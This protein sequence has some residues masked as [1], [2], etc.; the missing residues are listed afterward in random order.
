[1]LSQIGRSRAIPRPFACSGTPAADQWMRDV[2]REMNLSETAFLVPE[3][4]GF[5]PALVHAGGG[6]GPL[7]SRHR[8]QRA[9]PLGRCT[10]GGRGPGAV[11]HTQ[12]PVAGGPARR[13]DRTG[14]SRDARVQR[15]PR[16]PECSRPWAAAASVVARNGS[17][18]CWS[19]TRKKAVRGLTPDFSALRGLEMRG[20]IVTARAFHGGLRFRFP[21]LR[22]RPWAWM[23]TR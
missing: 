20:V 3:N 2:A 22:T 7:R 10:F 18:I 1:M 5:R 19:W 14:L 21:V 6:S 9:C 13:L 16:R 4:G 23:R 11:L 12:R 15:R 8:G 17:T